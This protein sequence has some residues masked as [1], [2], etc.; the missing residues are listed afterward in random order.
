MKHSLFLAVSHVHWIITEKIKQLNEKL[1]NVITAATNL[2]LKILDP[3]RTNHARNAIEQINVIS[4][5]QVLFHIQEIRNDAVKLG[6]WN[7]DHE[8]KLNFLGNLLCNEHDWETE[9]VE[10]YLHEVISTGPAVNF[11][12]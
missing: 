11:E 7:E 12:D 6:E 5:L 1:C 4:E 9:Q 2:I 3:E 8:G 10:R